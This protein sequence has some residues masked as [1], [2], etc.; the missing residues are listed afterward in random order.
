MSIAFLQKELRKKS[1]LLGRGIEFLEKND[2]RSLVERYL[3]AATMKDCSL[4][5]C[6][7]NIHLMQFLQISM[8]LVD[9][10]SVNENMVTALGGGGYIR[11]QGIDDQPLYFAY[12][13]RIVDLDPKSAKVNLQFAYSFLIFEFK[14]L[15]P[16]KCIQS[17]YCRRLDDSHQSEYPSALH[18]DCSKFNITKLTRITS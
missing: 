17:I 18:F 1:N 16:G 9:A 5:V 15:E 7:P 13:I 2:A 10:M 11:V 3:L 8:R 6:S 4:M 14:I 12:S